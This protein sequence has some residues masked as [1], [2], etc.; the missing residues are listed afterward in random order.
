M[1]SKITTDR[2]PSTDGAP[3]RASDSDRREARRSLKAAREGNATYLADEQP[4]SLGV[5]VS[6]MIAASV[7]DV[8]GRLSAVERDVLDVLARAGG[9]LP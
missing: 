1:S 9:L 8:E 7:A 4:T 3:A 2:G 6:P 5:T